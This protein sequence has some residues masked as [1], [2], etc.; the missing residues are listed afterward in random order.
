M[1]PPSE[2]EQQSESGD[3][4]AT[5]EDKEVADWVHKQKELRAQKLHPDAD[6]PALHAVALD[7]V[8]PSPDH[9]EPSTSSQQ[10]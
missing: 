9:E 1:E 7:K 5:T 3:A 2:P 4:S 8:V 10:D 6:K